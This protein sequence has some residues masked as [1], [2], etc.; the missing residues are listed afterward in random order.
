MTKL[1]DI[2]TTIG[3]RRSWALVKI[4]Y[5]SEPDID[6]KCPSEADYRRCTA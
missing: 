4:I 2:S 1:R 6:G 3:K 5:F